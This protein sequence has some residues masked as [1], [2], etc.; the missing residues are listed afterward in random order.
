[1]E[2]EKPARL[3]AKDSQK[4]RENKRWKKASDSRLKN[5]RKFLETYCKVQKGVVMGL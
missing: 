4:A 5:P 2:R 1:M 3:K